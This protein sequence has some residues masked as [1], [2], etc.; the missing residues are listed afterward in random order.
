MRRR[1][2]RLGSSSGRF[3]GFQDG[4]I[5]RSGNQPAQLTDEAVEEYRLR[6][7]VEGGTARD[8]LARERLMLRFLPA[9]DEEP[10]RL[11]EVESAVKRAI[12]VFGPE[13]TEPDLE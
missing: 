3:D 10:A 7:Q 6:L 9:G 11:R 13:L 2:V 5:P 12:C 8:G 4:D 1:A